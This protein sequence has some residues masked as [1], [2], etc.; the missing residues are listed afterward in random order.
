MKVLSSLICVITAKYIQ[1]CSYNIGEGLE[2][3]NGREM[4]VGLKEGLSILFMIS[5][6]FIILRL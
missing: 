5:S 1:V 6:N 2:L 4:N 3:D